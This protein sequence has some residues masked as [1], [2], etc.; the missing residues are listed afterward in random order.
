M[1][2][3]MSTSMPLKANGAVLGELRFPDMSVC[4]TVVQVAHE[5]A[6]VVVLYRV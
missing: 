4:F 3:L 5:H 6:L 1:A 2:L